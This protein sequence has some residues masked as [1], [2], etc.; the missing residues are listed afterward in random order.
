MHDDS[1]GTGDDD[2]CAH[3]V[4]RYPSHFLVYGIY[5]RR[6]KYCVG[7][8]TTD[9]EI[10]VDLQVLTPMNKQKQ[11]LQFRLFVSMSVLYASRLQIN[12]SRDFN[13]IQYLKVY[14]T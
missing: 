4:L 14:R 6:R 3:L 10:L 8:K 13:H 2:G 1:Y 11:S 7:E 5:T 12:D 9:V